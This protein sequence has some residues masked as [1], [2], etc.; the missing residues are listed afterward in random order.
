MGRFSERQLKE[1][2]KKWNLKKNIDAQMASA[3]LKIKDKRKREDNKSTEF[4]LNDVPVKETN[5][6]RW[7]KKQKVGQEG[8]VVGKFLVHFLVGK[9]VL[10]IVSSYPARCDLLDP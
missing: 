7:R 10:I 5:L 6:E 9:I 2:A 3:M 1:K 4:Q 8:P